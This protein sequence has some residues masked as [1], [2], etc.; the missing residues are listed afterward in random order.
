MNIDVVSGIIIG[1][2]LTVLLTTL[3]LDHIMGEHTANDGSV[4]ERFRHD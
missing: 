4:D 3:L 2:L 1:I